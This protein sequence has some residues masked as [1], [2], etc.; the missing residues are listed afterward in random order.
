MAKSVSHFFRKVTDTFCVAALIISLFASH[1]ADAYQ[2]DDPRR[3][4]DWTEVAR[5]GFGTASLVIIG[6]LAEFQ[7]QMYAATMHQTAGAEVWRSFDGTVWE[8]VVGAGAATA[9]GFGDPSNKSINKIASDGEWLF[10]ALWNDASGGQIWRS[11]DGVTWEASV[12]PGAAHPP[13]F[14]KAENTGVTALGVFNGMVFAGTGSAH[15]KDGVELWLSRDHGATWEPVAGERFALRTALARESK[16]FLDIAEFNGA[17]YIST[18]DQ[19]TGGSEIWRATDGWNWQPVVGAP[20][21]YRAGMGKASDDMIYDLEPF[22]GR[23]YAGV[24]NWLREGGSMWRS[25]RDG[26]DWEVLIGGDVKPRTAGFGN[27]ANFGIT[28]LCPLGSHLY[29]STSNEQGA[30]LW[31]SADGEVWEQVMGPQAGVPA[32]FG[33]AGNRAIN[34]LFSYHG[35]LF[36]STDNPQAGAEIW[37][38]D[39]PTP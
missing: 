33:S 29:A 13:G 15:C 6:P 34:G 30:E 20:T 35:V 18:G 25:D 2:L 1:S 28:R 27:A 24:L 12:G 9:A 16:Y 37:R 36:A 39:A 10:A 22:G 11:A 32:G 23:L 31:R 21:K 17:V 5:G 8:P 3:A 26:D 4:G 7:G 38:L 14:G 19:R